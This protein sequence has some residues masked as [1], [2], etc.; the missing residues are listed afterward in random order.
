MQGQ[1]Q[2]PPS[3][4][5]T[6]Q[7]LNCFFS[8]QELLEAY[9]VEG[10]VSGRPRLLLTAAVP[11][12]KKNIDAGFQIAE[13]SKCVF[14]TLSP[15]FPCIAA[16]SDMPLIRYLDF[17]NVMTYDFHGNWEGVTGHHSPLYK[18]AQETGD[19][20]YLNTVS[21]AEVGPVSLI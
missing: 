2:V 16:A 10:N 9:E 3:E 6:N 14:P 12:N 8:M 21:P 19:N 15:P 18:R 20:V 7:R 13:I 4:N 11:A 17:I 5:H 1:S